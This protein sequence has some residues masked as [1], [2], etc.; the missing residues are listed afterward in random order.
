MV[1]HRCQVDKGNNEDLSGLGNIITILGCQVG[2]DLGIQTACLLAVVDLHSVGIGNPRQI[3]K[4]KGCNFSIKNLV[5]TMYIFIHAT[6]YLI[7]TGNNS[8]NHILP[9]I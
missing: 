5:N 4:F 6:A 9:K 2:V 1:K 3:L 8:V 7:V